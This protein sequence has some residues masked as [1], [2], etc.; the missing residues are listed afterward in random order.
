MLCSA[1]ERAAPIADG[2]PK[3]SKHEAS[4]VASH[5]Q[6]QAAANLYA[7]RSQSLH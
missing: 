2:Q 3:R 7:H 4:A 5:A 1:A 6:A